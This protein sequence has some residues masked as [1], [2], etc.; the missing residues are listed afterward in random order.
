MKQM[1]TNYR[2]Y[3]L[4]VLIM[5]AIVGLFSEPVDGLPF[6]KWVWVMIASKAIGLSAGYAAY[7]LIIRWEK[8]RVISELTKMINDI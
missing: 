1:L 6:S 3:M 7:K 8:Q 4:F 2:Y 5:T